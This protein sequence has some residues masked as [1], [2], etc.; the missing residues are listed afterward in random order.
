MRSSQHES[1]HFWVLGVDKRRVWEQMGGLTLSIWPRHAT[2]CHATP[3]PACFQFLLHHKALIIQKCVRGWLQRVKYQRMWRAAVVL[4]CAYRRSRA[5]RHFKT[6]KTE[7][8]STKG[9]KKLNTGM[10]NKIV[11]LQRKMDDQVPSRVCI[12]ASTF[13]HVPTVDKC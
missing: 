3:S 6:L 8:P 7:A 4:Q 5:L 11:Q 2:P 10:E 9:L 1:M 12:R 13:L